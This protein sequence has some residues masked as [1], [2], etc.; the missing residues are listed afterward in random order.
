MRFVG[1]AALS[2]TGGEAAREQRFALR[3]R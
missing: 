2:G 1:A 3:D